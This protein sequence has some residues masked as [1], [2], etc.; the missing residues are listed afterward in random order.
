M[1]LYGVYGEVESEVFGEVGDIRR[2]LAA[3]L[4][5]RPIEHAIDL[6]GLILGAPLGVLDPALA[7]A[8]ALV[9]LRLRYRSTPPLQL[10]LL[11][12]QLLLLAPPPPLLRPALLVD[13]PPHLPPRRRL[14]QHRLTNHHAN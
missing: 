8:P 6:P 4:I 2:L 3:Q 14:P 1:G 7:A 9:E 12:A 13:L 5:H 10:L 11:R